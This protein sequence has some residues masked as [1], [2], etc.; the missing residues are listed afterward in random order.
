MRTSG[1]LFFG[2]TVCSVVLLTLK[3]S[4]LPEHRCWWIIHWVEQSLNNFKGLE[5]QCSGCVK[6]CRGVLERAP[7]CFTSA[8]LSM[9][10]NTLYCANTRQH[11][12]YITIISSL[13]F[14][15][16]FVVCQHQ[17]FRL[18]VALHVNIHMNYIWIYLNFNLKYLGNVLLLFTHCISSTQIFRVARPFAPYLCV[19]TLWRSVSQGVT[20]T[21]ITHWQLTQ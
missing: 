21:I 13:Q 11:T 8:G 17:L 2:E 15:L 14:K 12:I 3:N 18:A 16:L 7:P 6:L 9:R 5:L 10:I 1:C 20:Q 19:K 4:L